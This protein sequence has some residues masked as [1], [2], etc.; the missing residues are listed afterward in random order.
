MALPPL[1]VAGAP[2]C[3]SPKYSVTPPATRADPSSTSVAAASVCFWRLASSKALAPIPISAAS[4]SASLFAFSARTPVTA[5]ARRERAGCDE[6]YP[7]IIVRARRRGRFRKRRRHD[8]RGGSRGDL[9]GRLFGEHEVD[10][11]AVPAGDVDEARRLLPTG[12]RCHD[13]ARPDIH[14]HRPRKGRLPHRDVVDRDFGSLAVHPHEQCP[15]ALAQLFDLPEDLGLALFADARRL[16][17]VPIERTE[18]AGVVPER[19]CV[20]PIL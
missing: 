16:V 18:G 7:E 14:D 15:H 4:L 9:R 12:Q 8:D 19:G 3:R 11:D 2:E 1:D 17:Q 13:P 10:R 20:I 5:P 6:A